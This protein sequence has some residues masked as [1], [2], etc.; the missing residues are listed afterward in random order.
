MKNSQ[1]SMSYISKV[2]L[3][4]CIAVVLASP[5]LFA[6][7]LATG[8][9]NRTFQDDAGEHKYVVFVPRNYSPQK[10]WPVILFLHGAGERGTDGVVQTQVGLGPLVRD[11]VNSFPFVVVFPQA[12]DTEGRL[13][14]GW[15]AES[16]DA[17]R[18]IRILEEVEKDYSIDTEQTILTGWSMGGYGAWS[19]AAAMPERWSAVVPLAG[20]GDPASATQIKEVPIWAFHG[21]NDL[22]IQASESREMVEAVREAGGQIRYDEIAGG[23]HDIWKTVYAEDGLYE[24]MLNPSVS[25]NV[26]VRANPG[27]RPLTRESQQDSDLPFRPAVEIPGVVYVRLGNEMLEALSYS[28]KEMVP[29][30]VLSG[31]IQDIFDSTTVQGRDFQIRFYGIGYYGSLV[32]ARVKA[33]Q[34]DRLNIQLGVRNVALTIS[35]ALVSGRKHSASTGPIQIVIGHRRPVW[36][37]IDVVPYVH[38]RRIRLGVISSRFDIPHD[39]WYVTRPAGVRTKGWG[40][41][42]EKVSDG[43]VQ[44]LYGSRQRIE[45]EVRS[46]VPSIV[47]SI[48]EQLSLTDAAEM[49][50]GFWPLP[51]Y[52][53]R[54]QI[55]PVDVATDSNGVSIGLGVTAAAIDP[56]QAPRIPQRIEEMRTRVES[57][58]PVRQLRV[59]VNPAMLTPLTQMLID[60]DVAR[61]HVLDI[62]EKEFA[63][64]ADRELLAKAIPDLERY[65]DDVEIWS[66]LILAEP[67]EVTDATPST[68]ESP[69]QARIESAQLMLASH[70][71]D[72]LE[73]AQA[74]EEEAAEE[75]DDDA[76]TT[77]A[78]DQENVVPEPPDTFEFRLPKVLIALAIRNSRDGSDDDWTPYAQIEYTIAQ[79]AH[80]E[81]MTD[82]AGRDVLRLQ[83]IG[84][85]TIST[86][87]NFD[88]TYVP[89]NRE[90]DTDQLHNLF[91]K[92][93]EAWTIGNPAVQTA[94][95]DLE[96]GQARLSLDDAG[97]SSPHLYVDFASPSIKLTN[98]H[99]EPLVYE[100]KGP[101]SRWGG[102]YTLE[103]GESHVFKVPYAMS[104][105]RR[106]DS[107]FQE[108]TLPVGSHSEFRVPSSGGAPGLFQARKSVREA[109]HA[110]VHISQFNAD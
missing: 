87:A 12:E 3:G 68:I 14:T 23:E 70:A 19:L 66:E 31:R 28:L 105:R 84:Q 65:G 77:D 64:F 35:G 22:A 17:K 51:V 76:E 85:P 20:G 37:S 86:S 33:Y 55:W 18:A 92:G 69:Q 95:E 98:S 49:V 93:W 4:A 99:D 82:S 110:Q 50:Q 72:R 60:A 43:L 53:P 96:F 36:L 13:L 5:S 48:E 107:R 94:V 11:R 30:D 1:F 71:I 52:R 9:V 21:E 26:V 74:A 67:L 47:S 29:R 24:W 73:F 81:V 104:F 58:D 80:A 108:Y 83:W 34:K 38:E 103:P 25:S 59:G 41:T 75:N 90:I 56:S 78:G 57:V 7:Q 89:Q 46:A 8:F 61:I 88:R 109:K 10:E 45:R 39:N 54:L 42:R 2:V 62:P 63:A 15:A 27:R 32:R 40:M 106:L 16:A 79:Q 101:Y 100:T 44:G 6:N 97:W 102:P 91:E